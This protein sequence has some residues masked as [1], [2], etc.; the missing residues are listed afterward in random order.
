MYLISTLPNSNYDLCNAD[1]D[2]TCCVN[3]VQQPFGNGPL[4]ARDYDILSTLWS[5]GEKNRP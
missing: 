4:H 2:V 1:Q 3:D 5:V